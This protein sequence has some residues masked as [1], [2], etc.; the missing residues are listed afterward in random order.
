M[1]VT[2]CMFQGGIEPGIH[3]SLLIEF[4]VAHKPTQPQW[5]FAKSPSMTGAPVALRV[6]KALFLIFVPSQRILFMN[7]CTAILD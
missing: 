6:I 4:T 2:I 1:T 5:L 7:E 3:D